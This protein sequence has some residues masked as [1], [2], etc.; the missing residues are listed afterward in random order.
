MTRR[1]LSLLI[2]VL[3]LAGCAAAPPVP[4]DNF[5][6]IDVAAP[7][8][9]A[10]PLLPGV[11][12]VH[13]LRAAGL[14]QERPVLFTGA[15]QLHS[16]RQHDYHF[17]NEPPPQMLQAALIS[18]L[19]A[20]GIAETVVTPDLRLPARFEIMGKVKRL[21]RVLAEP[22]G[23]HAELELAVIDTTATQLS[24]KSLPTLSP[25]SATPATAPSRRNAAIKAHRTGESIPRWRAAKGTAAMPQPSCFDGLSMRWNPSASS[26]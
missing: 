8:R 22:S 1:P 6:R 11:V 7:T 18:F 3:T 17:W 4:R 12:L 2:A 13:P 5:Y 26:P 15:G 21:E 10:R 9:E 24:R 16:M 23:V 20:G 19:R 14:L 25:T